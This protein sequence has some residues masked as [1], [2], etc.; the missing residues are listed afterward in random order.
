MS[1]LATPG[2]GTPEADLPTVHTLSTDEEPH[3]ALAPAQTATLVARLAEISVSRYS[4]WTKE[5]LDELAGMVE[6]GVE[7][8]VV[9]ARSIDHIW[10]KLNNPPR[11]R[12]HEDCTLDHLAAP[13]PDQVEQTA[14][15][16]SFIGLVRKSGNM[17][18]E[19][20][21]TVI[22]V[23]RD[24]RTLGR[25]ARGESTPIAPTSHAWR[26]TSPEAYDLANDPDL[27]LTPA[28]LVRD[29]IIDNSAQ[30]LES[31]ELEPVVYTEDTTNNLGLPSVELRV[32]ET[33]PPLPQ[34]QGPTNSPRF[35]AGRMPSVF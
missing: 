4:F 31:Q 7:H 32:G 30:P 1:L 16:L 19:T 28:D 21:T 13:D 35:Y 33:L 29:P 22:A 3:P 14:R 15:C 24:K 25:L 11:P 26:R 20:S 9:W 27:R 2:V 34:Q 23:A 18:S 12:R 17:Q 10:R 6:L 8:S 5:E